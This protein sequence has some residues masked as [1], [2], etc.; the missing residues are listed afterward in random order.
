MK[1]QDE[2][3]ELSLVFCMCGTVLIAVLQVL[4]EITNY[5]K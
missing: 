4:I 1:N 3:I 5:L 2:S